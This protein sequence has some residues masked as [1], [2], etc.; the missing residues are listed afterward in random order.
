MVVG[1]SFGNAHGDS[2]RIATVMLFPLLCELSPNYLPLELLSKREIPCVPQSRNN[3]LPAIKFRIDRPSPDGRLGEAISNGLHPRRTRDSACKMNSFWS[4]VLE[5]VLYGCNH[6]GAGCEH[7]ITNN[8]R[9]PLE[10]RTGKVVSCDLKRPFLV[11]L[12]IRKHEGVISAVKE[13]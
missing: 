7:R 6:G 9:S 5:E 13:A 1:A 10:F 4:S 3:I 11:M 12:T 2:D 8:Q